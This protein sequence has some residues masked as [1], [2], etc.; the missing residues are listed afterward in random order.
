M[1]RPI[2][3]RS[4]L[5][6]LA[7]AIAV[8]AIG[9]SPAT[10]P[11]TPSAQDGA[12][13]YTGTIDPGDATFVLRRITE[14]VPDREPIA[15]DLIGR[16]IEANPLDDT[17]LIEVAIANAWTEPLHGP[18]IVWLERLV[19]RG[20][21]VQNPDIV[22]SPDDSTGIAGP[23]AVGFD[24]TD[25]LGDDGVLS[26][27]ET[28]E[29]KAWVFRSPELGAFSFD[30]RAELSLEPERARI[31]GIVFGDGNANG[32][33]DDDEPP[34]A[35]AI[36]QVEGP[37]GDVVRVTTNERGFYR[38]AASWPGLH[39]LTVTRPHLPGEC[40]T[41]P[42]PLE[43]VLPP[44]RPTGLTSFDGAHFGIL[45]RCGGGGDGDVPH[46]I[47]VDGDLGD[48]AQDPYRLESLHLEGDVLSMRI[49]MSG[50]SPDLPFR[51]V[52]STAFMESLP[53][54]T[55]A[56]LSYRTDDCDAAWMTSRAFDLS[57]LRRAYVAAYGE[58]GEI[59]IRLETPHGDEHE[60]LFGP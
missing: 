6:G 33:R 22:E 21:Y 57:P 32:R 41:T 2:I 35:G 48:V 20:V 3:R 50:C 55:R 17:V 29:F 53:V 25:A 42:N 38:Y 5:V 47:L 15:I 52:V 16:R 26:P 31:S 23:G 56:V 37:L 51:M 27:G 12:D 44:D 30:A 46:V 34:I 36:V 58:P 10:D 14:P 8:L 9:C 59:V 24:Y 49:E 19:P 7:A 54:Q 1:N 45:P 28:S 13:Q 39:T 11:E 4:T 18:A 60:I 40:F 43:V